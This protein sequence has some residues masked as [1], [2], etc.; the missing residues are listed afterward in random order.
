[1]SE[2]S[3]LVL[4]LA[5]GAVAIVLLVLVLLRKPERAREAALR[6]EQRDGRGEL[7]QQLEGL[8]GRTDQRL[9]LLR[10]ALAEDARKARTEGADLQQRFGE[11]LGLRLQELTQRN[12]QRLAEMRS[13][14]EQKLQELQAEIGR[15]SCRERVCQYV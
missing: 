7:R 6:E 5:A 14:L 12:E 8:S 10:E 3:L 1:M 4:L 13:T 11:G 2:S 9:D 15:A